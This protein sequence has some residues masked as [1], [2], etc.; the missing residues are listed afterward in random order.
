MAMSMC[1]LAGFECV[2]VMHNGKPSYDKG[3]YAIDDIRQWCMLLSE[4]RR[5]IT[6]KGKP[7]YRDSIMQRVHYLVAHHPQ[8][9]WAHRIS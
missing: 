2:L 5:V 4:T 3:Y 9:F 7:K 8:G 1:Y 6:E